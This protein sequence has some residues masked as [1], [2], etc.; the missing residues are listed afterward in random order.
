M[1]ISNSRALLQCT[2][3][4]IIVLL[5]STNAIAQTINGRETQRLELVNSSITLTQPGSY[6]LSILDTGGGRCDGVFLYSLIFNFIQL[7]DSS[8]FIQKH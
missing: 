7:R 6:Q 8:M 2:L 4:A 3:L 5:F 1:S